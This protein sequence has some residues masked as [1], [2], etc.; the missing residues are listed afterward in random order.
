MDVVACQGQLPR[1]GALV[2]WEEPRPL[3][4]RDGDAFQTVNGSDGIV[5]VEEPC[6]WLALLKSR[7][8]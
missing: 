8:S 7:R 3:A 6:D 4:I 2:L 5:T 1:P